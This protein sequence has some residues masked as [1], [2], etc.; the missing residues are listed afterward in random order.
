MAEL[1]SS[2]WSADLINKV[3][4]DARDRLTRENDQMPSRS[5]SRHHPSMEDDMTTTASGDEP[6]SM[7][8]H[9]PGILHSY[10]MIRDGACDKLVYHMTYPLQDSHSLVTR[11]GQPIATSIS[12]A[13]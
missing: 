1:G 8:M 12:I 2:Y 13:F 9:V 7:D 4:K 10:D 5:D 11:T 6:T 3:F